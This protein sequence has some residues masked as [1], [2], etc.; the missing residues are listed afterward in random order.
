M[1]LAAA[2][3]IVAAASVLAFG[4]VI[5]EVVDHGIGSG[6]A[7]TLNDALLLFLGVVSLMALVRGRTGVPGQ[8]AR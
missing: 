8:L 2:A 6:N 7:A 1:T 3:L 5:R 4:V